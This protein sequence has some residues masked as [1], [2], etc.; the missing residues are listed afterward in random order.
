M[1]QG[2]VPIIRA[3]KGNAAEMVAQKLD[4]RLRDHVMNARNN[5]FTDGGANGVNFQRPGRFL[6]FT[7]ADLT[8]SPHHHGSKY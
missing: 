5:L 8:F 6:L 3:P 1:F 7:A 2:V 4:Q